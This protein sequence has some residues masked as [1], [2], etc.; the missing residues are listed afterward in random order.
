MIGPNFKIFFFFLSVDG[1]RKKVARHTETNGL[2]CAVCCFTG[3]AMET[4]GG[5]VWFHLTEGCSTLGG[6]TTLSQGARFFMNS[7]HTLVAK[8]FIQ[9]R[10]PA[11][12]KIAKNMLAVKA[13][14]SGVSLA[15]RARTRLDLKSLKKRCGVTSGTAARCCESV[16]RIN[17]NR[18]MKTS[19]TARLDEKKVARVEGS[20]L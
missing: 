16:S 2:V 17:S 8:P 5:S 9:Q 18:R 15:V 20:W 7:L 13:L 10:T 14:Y 12:K 11:P 6:Q 3:F 4:C 19:M 1:P